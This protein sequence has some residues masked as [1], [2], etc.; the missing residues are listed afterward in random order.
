MYERTKFLKK[1]KDG[2][3]NVSSS[4]LFRRVPN[5]NVLM[6]IPVF[7]PPLG[8]YFLEKILITTL[9]KGWKER[10]QKMNDERTLR[11][12]GP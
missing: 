7:P 4:T 3:A 11:I 8:D 2:N 1:N 10:T 9:K 6:E 12:N 5:F